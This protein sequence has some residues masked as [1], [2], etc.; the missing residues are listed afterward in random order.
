MAPSLKRKIDDSEVEDRLNAGEPSDA[1]DTSDEYG[2]SGDG[3]ETE[4][5]EE[6]VQ[7]LSIQRAAEADEKEMTLF[8]WRNCEWAE[9]PMYSISIEQMGQHTLP[10]ELMRL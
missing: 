1:D 10:R 8:L 6:L 4:V 3:D 2:Y 9:D 7:Q 5:D